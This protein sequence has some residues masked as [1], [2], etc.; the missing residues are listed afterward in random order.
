MHY[1]VE[2]YTIFSDFFFFFFF[3]GV[4]VVVNKQTNQPIIF[5][6]PVLFFFFFL[7]ILHFTFYILHF[8]MVLIHWISSSSSSLSSSFFI[9]LFFFSPL[10]FEFFFFG[11]LG[12]LHFFTR[13]WLFSINLLINSFFE[14][15][16]VLHYHY[17]AIASKI[18]KLR[19]WCC[20]FLTRNK[21]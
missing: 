17:H 19:S 12:T 18:N 5:R 21:H 7:S 16:L 3:F 8:N 14:K 20:E 10:F 13:F 6:Y 11:Y 2:G 1:K 15:R 9:S 4:R